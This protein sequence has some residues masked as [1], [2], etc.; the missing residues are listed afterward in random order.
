MSNRLLLPHSA[1]NLKEIIQTFS[2]CFFWVNF[3]MH[4]LYY[5]RLK[6]K[7]HQKNQHNRIFV[8]KMSNN[9]PSW[10]GGTLHGGSGVYTEVFHFKVTHNAVF[11]VHPQVYHSRYD[12]VGYKFIINI[13]LSLNEFCNILV[14]LIFMNESLY[15]VFG[16]Y[17]IC[18]HVSL[19]VYTCTDKICLYGY[20]VS[21]TEKSF[22]LFVMVSFLNGIHAVVTILVVTCILWHIRNIC[23]TNSTRRSRMGRWSWWLKANIDFCFITLFFFCDWVR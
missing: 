10:L 15:F 8:K 7:S 9:L 20:N 19:N 6:Y 23:I 3:C 18:N 2:N 1:G 14:F 5:I 11:H 22:K 12:S 21:K 16:Y 4:N 17:V 13:E